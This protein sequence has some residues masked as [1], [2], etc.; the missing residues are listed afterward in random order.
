MRCA[1]MYAMCLFYCSPKRPNRK[2]YETKKHTILGPE[3]KERK[4][5]SNYGS[6][7]GRHKNVFM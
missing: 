2:H 5:N 4:Q 1:S 7:Q 3:Q 6:T